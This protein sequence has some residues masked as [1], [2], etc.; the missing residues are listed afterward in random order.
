M[1]KGLEDYLM[2]CVINSTVEDVSKKERIGYRVLVSIM[3]SRIDKPVDWSSIR[4]F[5]RLALMK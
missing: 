5:T 4:I 1:T 3:K 2:R